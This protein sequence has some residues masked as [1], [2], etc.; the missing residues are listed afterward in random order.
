MG[1]KR[2]DGAVDVPS[3]YAHFTQKRFDFYLLNI[4]VLH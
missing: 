1:E 4:G 3:F 2:G